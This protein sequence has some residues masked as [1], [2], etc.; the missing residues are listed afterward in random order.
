MIKLKLHNNQ[1]INSLP[2]EKDTLRIIEEASIETGIEAWGSTGLFYR[3]FFNAAY[4]RS[5]E[6][7]DKDVC[8]KSMQD[9]KILWQFLQNHW[10]ETRWSVFSGDLENFEYGLDT[11]HWSIQAGRSLSHRLGAVKIENGEVLVL[12]PDFVIDE[13]KDGL[14]EINTYAFKEK[15]DKEIEK[16]KNSAVLR[17]KKTISEYPFLTLGKTFRELGIKEFSSNYDELSL[18]KKNIIINKKFIIQSP[19]R[20]LLPD[21]MQSIVDA[22]L[23][24]ETYFNLSATEKGFIETA[25]FIKP[26]NNIVWAEYFFSNASDK[27]FHEWFC[28]Q[29]RSRHP[30]GGKDDFINSI[31]STLYQE[32]NYDIFIHDSG[33]PYKKYLRSK[34]LEIKTDYRPELLKAPVRLLGLLTE[35]PEMTRPNNLPNWLDQKQKDAIKYLYS[36]YKKREDQLLN[37][38]KSSE[39]YSKAISNLISLGVSID[40]ISKSIYSLANAKNLLVYDYELPPNS[41]T[42]PQP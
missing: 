39:N 11:P 33:L 1:Y 17:A 35:L 31:F 9:A 19:K 23:R 12:S 18:E 38:K 24:S 4:G 20:R 8:V 26:K 6:G 30:I 5:Q 42:F 32:N 28:N 27:E 25:D 37:N 2:W 41:L 15:N 21:E 10:P 3:P 16:F 29:T 22:K 13:L 14:I 40:D 7:F 36:V 34:I